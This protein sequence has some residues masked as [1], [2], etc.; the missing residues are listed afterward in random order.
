METV[1]GNHRFGEAGTDNPVHIP[2]Y[3]LATNIWQVFRFVDS[4]WYLVSYK[5]EK[6]HGF[7]VRSHVIMQ[8]T[9]K[10]IA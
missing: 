7:S 5:N 8:V 1:K 6:H 4:L 9:R 3:V 2:T 10:Y